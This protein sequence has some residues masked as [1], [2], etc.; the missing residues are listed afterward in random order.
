MLQSYIQLFLGI[1]DVDNQ[2][3]VYIPKYIHCHIIVHV[4]QGFLKADM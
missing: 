4:M 2:I 1:K 3:E